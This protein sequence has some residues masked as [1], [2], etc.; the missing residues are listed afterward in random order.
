MLFL[1]E[2][3]KREWRALGE[4]ALDGSLAWEAGEGKVRRNLWPAFCF[5]AGTLLAAKGQGDRGWQW[6]KAGVLGEEDGLFCNAFLLSFLERQQRRLA[7]P[8]VIFSDPRPFM[9]WASVPTMARAR[10]RFVRQLGHTLPSF[11]HPLRVMDIGCGDGALTVKWLQNLLDV[12]KAQEIGE[13]LLIDAS[14]A[15]IELARK[16]VGEAFPPQCI[17]TIQA[18]IEQCSDQIEGHYDIAVASLAIHHMPIEQKRLQLERLLP[19]LDHFV[20]FELDANHDTPELFSPELAF[21]VYQCYGRIIDFVF[22]HDSTVEL[23]YSSVDSFLM[24]EAV[25]ILTQP[26]GQRTDYHMLR[27]QWDE[28]FRQMLTGFSKGCDSTCYAD[29]YVGLYTLH[30]GR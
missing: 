12:G 30:Y 4:M 26:R 8:T 6:L 11:G 17:R 5:Y 1:T 7:V 23:A 10:E 13:I 2:A 15:M 16:T 19:H 3:E 24:A 28:L 14:P 21:S 27:V 20:L 18:K 29:E 22:S 9:H 25:S